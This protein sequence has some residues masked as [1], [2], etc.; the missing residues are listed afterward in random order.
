MVRVGVCLSTTGEFSGYGPVNLAGMRLFVNDYNTHPGVNRVHLE[1]VVRDDAS[2]PANAVRI[3][4]EFARDGLQVVAGGV[5]SNIMLAMLEPAKKH[6]IVVISPAATSPKIG[7]ADVWGYKILPGDDYQGGALARFFARQMGIKRAAAVV[8]GSYE[9]GEHIY[10]A[11]KKVMEREGGKIV[12]EERYNWDLDKSD[13]F[14]FTDILRRLAEAKPETVLLPGYTKD[15]V[16]LIRQTEGLRFE[17]IFCGGDSWLNHKEIFPA[18]PRLDDS[19]YIGGAEVY[20]ST[21]QAKHFAELLDASSDPNLEPYSV[22][23]Y[24]VMLILAGAFESGARKAGEIRDWINN[25]RHFALASGKMNYDQVQGTSKTLYI[26]RIR[27]MDDGFF[28][29]MVAEMEP[30]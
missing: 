14:D 6:G 22:D 30:E 12:A 1:L 27:K 5:T 10:Q 11:F 26:Y 4:E 9:Y 15:A 13:S 18:G 2:K 7:P 23:G 25:K 24:D 21:P 19:Y 29:E 28:S 17:T 20:A 8:N 16:T 3:M